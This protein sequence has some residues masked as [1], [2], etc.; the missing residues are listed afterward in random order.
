MAYV[1]ISEYAKTDKKGRTSFMNGMRS[2]LDTNPGTSFDIVTSGSEVE[3]GAMR[4]MNEIG[5]GKGRIP[6]S[7]ATANARARSS[8]SG[9]VCRAGIS[10]TNFCCVLGVRYVSG[11][12][13]R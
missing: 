5:Q 13:F 8:T 9:D 7:H 10:S 12:V 3:D 6:F 2:A 1:M 11:R 4:R